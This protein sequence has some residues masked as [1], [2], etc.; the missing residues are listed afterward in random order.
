MG[1]ADSRHEATHS[2]ATISIRL[3][4]RSPAS[5]ATAAVAANSATSCAASTGSGVTGL[6]S[7]QRPLRPPIADMAKLGWSRSSGAPPLVMRTSRAS[8]ARGHRA[9]SASPPSGESRTT[10]SNGVPGPPGSSATGHLCRLRSRHRRSRSPASTRTTVA[11]R[12]ARWRVAYVPAADVVR[13]RTRAPSSKVIRTASP[14][15]PRW[16]G[17]RIGPPRSTACPCRW[18]SRSPRAR[19]PRSRRRSAD[20]RGAPRRPTAPAP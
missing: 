4:E 11:P 19:G 18:R 8:S 3:V 5:H 15:R 17:R 7:P 12:S 10:T 2:S 6:S 9:A 13:S 16:H 14:A 1:R 20:R